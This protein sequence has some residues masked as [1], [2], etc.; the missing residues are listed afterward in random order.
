[1]IKKKITCLDP[2]AQHMYII[3]EREL[4]D[5]TH[6]FGRSRTVVGPMGVLVIKFENKEKSL[7]RIS[8]SAADY[9]DN[10][11]KR[12]GLNIAYGRLKS[13]QPDHAF[14]IESEKFI[15]MIE[16]DNG[17]LTLMLYM[18][19]VKEYSFTRLHEA[20]YNN[21]LVNTE[22]LRSVYQILFERMS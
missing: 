22:K 10:F 12:H 15:E 7:I 4:L 2:E 16:D 6:L 5:K 9:V 21:T 1:M 19:K 17:F 20:A 13:N 14:V 11:I 8:L 18:G 3:E